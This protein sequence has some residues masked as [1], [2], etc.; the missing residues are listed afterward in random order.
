[1]AALPYLIVGLGI[2]VCLFYIVNEKN[3]NRWIR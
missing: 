1:M 2:V 3:V